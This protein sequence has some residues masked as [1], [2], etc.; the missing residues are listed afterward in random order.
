MKNDLGL[1]EDPNDL[2]I[3]MEGLM[4]EV[5]ITSAYLDCNDDHDANDSAYLWQVII[6]GIL[7]S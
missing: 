4:K 2:L 6:K 7:N 5:G 1:A 3:G